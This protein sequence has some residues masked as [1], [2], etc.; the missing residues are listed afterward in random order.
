VYLSIELISNISKE[1]VLQTL[2]SGEREREREREFVSSSKEERESPPP[3]S[4]KRKNINRLVKE[5]ER[6][7]RESRE[8]MNFRENRGKLEITLYILVSIHR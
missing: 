2:N 6:E 7:K 3:N 4:R 8:S 5:R 1:R